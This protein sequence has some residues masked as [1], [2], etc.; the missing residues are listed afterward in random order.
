MDWNRDG[1]VDGK[2]CV[3]FHEVINKDSTNEPANTNSGGSRS[4][5]GSSSGTPRGLEMTSLGKAILT[6]LVFMVGAFIAMGSE[7]DAI[8]QL[9]KIG[10]VVFLI[11]QLL[12]S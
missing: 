1:K 11:G 9:I 8:W 7:S 10:L 12:D 4:G 3:M 6:I 2:D 5:G